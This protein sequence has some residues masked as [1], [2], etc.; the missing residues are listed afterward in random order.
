[1][2]KSQKW[3]D[4]HSESDFQFQLAWNIKEMYPVVDVALEYCFNDG[5][6]DI[7][8]SFPDGKKIP[9]EL[10]YF[11]KPVEGY[12]L[13]T[14][15][16]TWRVYEVLKDVSRIERFIEDKKTNGYTIILSNASIY[17]RGPS[18]K[19]KPNY[20]NFALTD[21]KKL[22]AN[23]PLNWL[24]PEATAVT[25][26]R[27]NKI[28][29]NKYLLIGKIIKRKQIRYLIIE[30]KLSSN[31]IAIKFSIWTVSNLNIICLI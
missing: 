19:N 22:E 31:F 18:E 26:S 17:W 6:I 10:K 3:W 15:N 14:Q 30:S 5:R 11:V 28:V 13:N 7:V 4:F 21:G 23:T 8:T 20:Y 1:M 16:D 9:I 29:L 12:N 27:K 24:D 25:E 2:C